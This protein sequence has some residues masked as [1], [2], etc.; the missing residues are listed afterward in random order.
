MCTTLYKDRERVPFFFKVLILL[1]LIYVNE[2]VFKKINKFNL[3][4]LTNYR[5]MQICCF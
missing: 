4:N 5:I 2:L 1:E 3:K